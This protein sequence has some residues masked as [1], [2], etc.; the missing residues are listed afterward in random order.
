MA[1]GI[2]FYG[3]VCGRPVAFFVF[4]EDKSELFRFYDPYSIND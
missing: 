2:P 3:T 4:L 1:S